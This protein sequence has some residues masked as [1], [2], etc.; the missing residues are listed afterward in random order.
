MRKF[1]ALL[2]LTGLVVSLIAG[3]GPKKTTLHIYNWADYLKPELLQRFEQEFDC[4]VVQDFFD[5]NESMYAKLKAG[6]TG[7]DVIFPSSYMIN[8]MK[9]Q[10]MLLP[11]D[12]AKLPNLQ[13][14]DRAYLKFTMDEEMS[15]SVPYMVGSTGLGYLTSRVEDFEPTWAMFDHADYAG[16][17]TLLNDMREVLGAALKFL[18]YSLNTTDEKQLAEARDVAIRW[19]HNIAKY[20]SEQYK[21]GLVSAE[22]VLSQ[23]YSGDVLQA[24]D[25]SDDVAYAVPK[26]GTSIAS[27]DMVIPK[28]AREVDL[29]HAFINFIH[30]PDVAAENIEYV[31]YLCPNTAAYELLSEEIRTDE[32]IFLPAE[33]VAK[34]EVILDLGEE[35]AKYVAMW[36][37]VKAA[38]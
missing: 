4:R 12:H 19:K 25:E 16:R 2:G 26:E 1:T 14:I 34:S 24:M 28:G 5:S 18:G 30:T 31:Y 38:E 6:A 20:D 21:N 36:D 3:C 37:Q 17:M 7:Y 27:D 35:N 13:H 10:D 11:L 32:S 8:I 29:A 23:G 9:G 15:H 22:F 33:I